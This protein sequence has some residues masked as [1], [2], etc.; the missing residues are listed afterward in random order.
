VRESPDTRRSLRC[1]SLRL[2]IPM[3]LQVTA[4]VL[5]YLLGA[6]PWGLVLVRVVKGVDLRTVGS[7]NIGATN[8]MRAA[9]KPLG[10]AVFVLDFLKGW[11][12]LHVFAGLVA[13]A[14]ATSW[15]AMGCGAAA[16]LGHCFPVW[17]GFKG[18]KGVATGCGALVAVQPWIWIVGGAVWLVA[19]A[20]TRMV[21][22]A[23][24]AM[25]LAFPIAA[26]FTVEP[27]LA[28]TVGAGALAVLILVRHRSNMARIVAGTEPKAFKKRA[29]SEQSRG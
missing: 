1:Y 10:L 15:L 13:G 16:V 20:T 22:L 28:S 18:G 23:S 14:P 4:L 7:G 25:G 8:A 27:P 2:R 17:L 21:S 26:W 5:S 24:I 11:C 3:P 12:A 29:D 19:L 9:G 6:V